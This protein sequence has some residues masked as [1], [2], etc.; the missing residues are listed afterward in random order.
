[1]PSFARGVPAGREASRVKW[2]L[3]GDVRRAESPFT[4]SPCPSTP[5]PSYLQAD[6]LGPWGVFLQ[7]IDRVTPYLGQLAYWVESLKRPK[8]ILIVDVP[9]KL[10][11]GSVAHFE[12]YRVQHNTSRGPGKG[13]VRFHQ[14]V[15]LSEVMALA[16]WMTVK[17]AAIGVPFGGAK[18]GVRVDP[19]GS[20]VGR[21]RARDAPL[22]ERDRH[23]RSV[24]TRTSPRP[25]S[26]PTSRS[27]RG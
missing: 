26:T 15:T 5:I 6:H 24:R 27:W 11:D 9:I 10:D 16:G 14:D 4:G 25:T 21:A 12:G 7:Q 17:N 18:G 13:G 3:S 23:R 20:V 8:R 2:R 19:R 1:M 22:H